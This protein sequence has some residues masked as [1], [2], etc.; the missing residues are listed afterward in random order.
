MKKRKGEEGKPK[1][2]STIESNTHQK[3]QIEPL[4][5]K[6]PKK[7]LV[8]ITEQKIIVS[9]VNMTEAELK[10]LTDPEKWFHEYLPM[11]R[12]GG[13]PIYKIED[14][15]LVMRNNICRVW[16]GVYLGYL[17]PWEGK[18][19]DYDSPVALLSEWEID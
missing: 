3:K 5:R 13:N 14:A 12:R 18:P 6:V 4:K 11:I 9:G 7:L 10:L 17:N 19:E 8:S 15:G 1:R 16:S 2:K